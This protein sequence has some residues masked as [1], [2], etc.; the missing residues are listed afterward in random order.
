MRVRETF[1]YREKTQKKGSTKEGCCYIKKIVEHAEESGIQWTQPKPCDSSTQDFEVSDSISISFETNDT[2]SAQSSTVVGTT[3][4]SPSCYNTPPLIHVDQLSPRSHQQQKS[5]VE[6]PFWLTFIFG[7]V[8]RCNG[9]KGKIRRG[10]GKALLP[11]PDDIVLGHKEYVVYQNIHSGKFEMSQDERSVSYHPWKTCITS[12]FRDFS[13][14]YH[15]TISDHIK[16][17]LQDVHKLFLKSEF[18]I[19]NT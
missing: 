19:I 15:I 7:N 13:P 16:I 11:P 17:N 6:M 18:G 3:S 5:S 1:I 9:C 2:S 14:R 12:N 4:S 8:S 10:E